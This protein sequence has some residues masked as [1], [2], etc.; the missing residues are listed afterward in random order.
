MYSG[1]TVQYCRFEIIKRNYSARTCIENRCTYKT[2]RP[3]PLS[4][5]FRIR[6]LSFRT[7]VA[8]RCSCG[9][10]TVIDPL[11]WDVLC[12]IRTFPSKTRSAILWIVSPCM[13]SMNCASSKMHFV[14]KWGLMKFQRLVSVRPWIRYSFERMI[15][16]V[17]NRAMCQP[18]W[19][20][21]MPDKV[22][23]LIFLLAKKRSIQVAILRR[24]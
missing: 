16:Q 18:T 11:I 21:N 19:T 12:G 10:L 5:G 2:K 15:F 3:P 13:M 20:K 8:T 7:K 24:F 6:N 14:K 1:F 9:P 17:Q 4:T 23:M 22:Q